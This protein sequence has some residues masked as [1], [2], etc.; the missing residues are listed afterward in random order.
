MA[1]TADILTIPETE[2]TYKID[3]WSRMLIFAVF[4]FI[5]I[6]YQEV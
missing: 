5:N 2:W 3:A 4:S 6:A 1:R